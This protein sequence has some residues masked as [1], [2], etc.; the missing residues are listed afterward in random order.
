M[1]TYVFISLL[2][3]L[4]PRSKAPV[5]VP[6]EQKRCRVCVGNDQPVL[7]FLCQRDVV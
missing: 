5:S 1:L 4:T 3:F 6:T 7:I 2:G